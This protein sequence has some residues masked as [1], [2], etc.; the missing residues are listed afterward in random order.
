AQ[1]ARQE[2]A[3]KR[4]V[5]AVPLRSRLDVFHTRR[6]GE[7]ALRLAWAHAETLWEEAEKLDRAKARFDRSGGDGRPFKK[8]VAGK[9]WT[10]AIAAFEEAQ[11]QEAAW[12]RAVTALALFRPDGQ[13]NDR[14]WAAAELRA[15]AAA[16][17]GPRWAKTRRMLLD[18]RS[19][20]FL[21]RLHEEL[22]ALAPRA[23]GREALGGRWRG[24]RG[25]LAATGGRE[26]GGSG[27]RGGGRRWWRGWSARWG[28]AGKS[29]IGRRHG[30]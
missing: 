6:E 20:T 12:R 11:R 29:C 23:G 26:G 3:A 9:A 24:R 28:R 8:N 15:A 25:E 1:R 30:C 18:E 5:E 22:A 10:Q 14:A 2:A 13:L 7:R 16:L 21:D 17:P 19:L 4:R 27:Q